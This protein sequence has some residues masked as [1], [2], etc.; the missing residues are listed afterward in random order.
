MTLKTLRF[1]ISMASFPAFLWASFIAVH[2]QW[3]NN[4]F[5]LLGVMHMC[6]CMRY[7]D[8]GIEALKK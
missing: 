6:N 1:Y 2:N 3:A 4:L 8:D 5:I 7:L